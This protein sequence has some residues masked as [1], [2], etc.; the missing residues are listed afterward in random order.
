MKVRMAFE[1]ELVGSFRLFGWAAEQ[2]N[3]RLPFKSIEKTIVK[4]KKHKNQKF[5]KLWHLNK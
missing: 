5:W 2:E 1:G 3:Q 4:T